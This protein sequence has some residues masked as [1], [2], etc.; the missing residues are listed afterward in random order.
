[1]AGKTK[2]ANA[3]VRTDALDDSSSSPD[4]GIRPTVTKTKGT[5]LT[6]YDDE[7]RRLEQ[8]LT[9]EESQ[10]DQAERARNAN[11]LRISEL[12]AKLAEL[13]IDE[14]PNATAA[15]LLDGQLTQTFST[16]QKLT[17]FRQLFR[18]REDVY[19]LRWQS[20]KTGASGYMP[21][22]ARVS[23]MLSSTHYS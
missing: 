7:R 2:E 18:G 6:D 3:S 8:Q 5:G 15:A 16:E 19:P 20:K 14:P 12:K 23:T 4:A 22:W 21:E 17:I 1:M 13:S 11:R 10:L 9:I